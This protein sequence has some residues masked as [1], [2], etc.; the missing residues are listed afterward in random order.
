MCCGVGW[1]HPAREQ[2]L[3]G[4]VGH[5]PVPVWPR[6]QAAAAEHVLLPMPVAM[7]SLF[8]AA[9]GLGGSCQVSSRCSR[10]TMCVVSLQCLLLPFFSFCGEAF[11]VSV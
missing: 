9:A 1:V 11:L 4:S 2:E 6:G 7:R 5:V 3:A 10:V 8:A